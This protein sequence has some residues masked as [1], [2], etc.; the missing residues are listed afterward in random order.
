MIISQPTKSKDASKIQ[1]I[2]AKSAEWSTKSQDAM[3]GLKPDEVQKFSDWITKKSQEL[4][5][6]MIN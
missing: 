3:K 2:A 5:D 4:S 6:A 1:A